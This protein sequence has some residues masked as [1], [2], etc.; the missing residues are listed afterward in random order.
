MVLF[1][2]PLNNFKSLEKMPAVD[3]LFMDMTGHSHIGI[4]IQSIPQSILTPTLHILD[5]YNDPQGNSKEIHE[6]NVFLQD[7]RQLFNS[8]HYFFFAVAI[9]K[10]AE[11]MKC[12]ERCCRPAPLAL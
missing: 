2:L 9:P 4:L 10:T 7:I 1:Q 11:P 5:K 3:S 8:G 12:N 6:I